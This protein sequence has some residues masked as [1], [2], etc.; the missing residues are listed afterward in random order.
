MS[1]RGDPG[2]RDCSASKIN[3]SVQLLRFGGFCL[4]QYFPG[5]V[6]DQASQ[7]CILYPDHWLICAISVQYIQHVDESAPVPSEFSFPLALLAFCMPLSIPSRRTWSALGCLRASVALE[8]TQLDA[9]GFVELFSSLDD[10]ETSL[11]AHRQPSSIKEGARP[12]LP[13]AHNPSSSAHLFAELMRTI[14]KAELYRREGN[15]S[16][17]W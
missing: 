13:S 8:F 5:L 10:S 6:G 4:V 12:Q 16:Q 15:K 1:E 17:G 3:G 9:C 11:L 7:G 2:R 14:D